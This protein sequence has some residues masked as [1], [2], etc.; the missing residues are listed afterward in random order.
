MLEED[1]YFT[2]KKRAKKIA[3]VT[4]PKKQVWF[5]PNH[6]GAKQLQLNGKIL[7][8]IFGVGI[9]V[10]ILRRTSTNFGCQRMN[11][12]PENERATRDY[13]TYFSTQQEISRPVPN[14]G[15]FS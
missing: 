8:A 5:Q 14:F 2:N 12:L 15:N 13:I 3:W 1:L 10:H 7:T 11:G 6:S 4:L 9:T